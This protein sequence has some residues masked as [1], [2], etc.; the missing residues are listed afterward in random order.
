MVSIVWLLVVY[1]GA[2]VLVVLLI[3]NSQRQT[4]LAAEARVLEEKLHEQQQ[5]TAIARDEAQTST[6]R[7]IEATSLADLRGLSLKHVTKDLD[8]LQKE[9]LALKSENFETLELLDQ[10]LK[11]NRTLHSQMKSS[12]V[13][14][15][16]IAENLAPFLD[17]FPY[18]PEKCRFVGNPIDFIVFDD[19]YIRVVE[20]KSGDA[21]L[22]KVQR[23][24]RDQIAEGRIT[25]EVFRVNGEPDATDK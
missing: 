1:V 10:E 4:R 5:L 11:K 13:R 18:D 12:Q 19:D 21:Q 24:I 8:V 17:S 3:I 9:A 2:V 20:V 6:A 15:G 14:I 22:A 25:F 7:A 23:T 16:K